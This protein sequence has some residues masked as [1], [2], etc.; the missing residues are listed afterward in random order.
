M[1]FK[2]RAYQRDAFT[3]INE[4]WLEH[5]SVICNIP[6][7]LGKIAIAA[8]V[9]HDRATSGSKCCFVAD[10]NELCEQPMRGIFKVTGELP[11]L[12]KASD[13]ARRDARFTVASLQRPARDN[14]LEGQIAGLT[15]KPSERGYQMSEN[16]NAQT[17]PH[18][19]HAT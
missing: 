2:L 19:I 13:H 8:A 17:L 9:M 6:T 14:R 1:T 10:T 3:A 11:A 5:R 16:S 4:S 15:S 18:S 7:G 12:E